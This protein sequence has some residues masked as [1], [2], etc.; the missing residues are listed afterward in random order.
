MS[1]RSSFSR[2]TQELVERTLYPLLPIIGPRH[3]SNVARI[4]A[5][6]RAGDWSLTDGGAAVAGGIRLEPDEFT[7]TARA[8]P[9]HEIADEGDLLVA[10]DTTID[11]ELAAEAC[12]RVAH[13]LQNLRKAAGLEVSGRIESSVAAPSM[14]DR[15]LPHRA[16]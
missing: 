11:D 4:M 10:L 15:L 12:S 14:A 8:R 5:A 7:L 2:T 1:G 9:G 6:V 3:G 16:G 13:R